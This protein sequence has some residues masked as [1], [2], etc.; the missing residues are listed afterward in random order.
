MIMAK[1]QN[2]IQDTWNFSVHFAHA[3]SDGGFG[4]VRFGL[5]WFQIHVESWLLGCCWGGD[6][7]FWMHFLK[8]WNVL[9]RFLGWMMINP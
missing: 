1:I 6:G 3:P 8:G 4:S 9:G 2:D 7:I 5:D